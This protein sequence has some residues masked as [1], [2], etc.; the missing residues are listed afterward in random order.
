[1]INNNE[2]LVERFRVFL[3]ADSDRAAT[4]TER[5]IDLYSLFSEL[6]AL[7]NEV[8]IE[9]RQFKNSLDDFKSVFTTLDEA[10]QNLTEKLEQDQREQEKI[11]EQAVQ[12]LLDDLIDIHDRLAAGLAVL[13]KPRPTT[14]FS[15]FCKQER[16]TL[17][18][19]GQG[20][21]MILDKV[22]SILAANG[23]VPME[24]EGHKFDPRTMRAMGTAWDPQR[25]EGEVIEE[26]RKG[27]LRGDIAM[28]LA[29]VKINKGDK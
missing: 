24:V 13:A 23:V 22:E 6:T 5:D 20:Q 16:A 29:E 17:D 3:A 2:E 8:R 25:A 19:M 26:I 10:N 15:R 11:K 9:S 28:R 7:K 14:M 1:M 12:P 18:A 27:F 21:K 4:T